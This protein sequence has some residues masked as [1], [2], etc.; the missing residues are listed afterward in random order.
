LARAPS[1]FDA[2][3]VYSH[4]PEN[5]L[6]RYF[7]SLERAAERWFEGHRDLNAEEVAATVGGRIVFRAENGQ[8]WA[9]V[10]VIATQFP[11]P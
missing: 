2:V 6:L 11:S 5:R 3:L 4:H 1:G 10:V 8:Q 7:P 9:A